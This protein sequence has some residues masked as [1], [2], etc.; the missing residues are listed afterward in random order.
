MAF[1]TAGISECAICH[2]VLTEQDEVFAT[3]GVFGVDLELFPY[4]DAPMHW[5][6]Y[7][8]WPHRETFARAYFDF[9]I[10]E[11]RRNRYWAKVYL[12]DRV[13]MKVNPFNGE[14]GE[15]SLLLSRTGSS[16]RVDLT[17]W[18]QWLEA[19]ETT[20]DGRKLHPLEVDEFREIAPVLKATLPTWDSVMDAIDGASKGWRRGPREDA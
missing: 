16:V 2:E 1:F 15:A 5:S 6:C 18:E 14:N 7:A 10:E 4:C 8:A 9:W 17:H 3:W 11:E 19:A 12:D 20:K 13:L